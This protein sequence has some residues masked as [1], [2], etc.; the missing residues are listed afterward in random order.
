MSF[1]AAKNI[2]VADYVRPN[3]GSFVDWNGDGKKDFIG[4]EF[5]H[6]IRFYKN[7]GSG[8]DG[9]EPKFADAQG[10]KIVKPY[11]IMM[12]SGADAVD[13]NGDGDIDIITG[14]GH[15]G[16]GIRFY[17]RDYI[18]DSLNDTHPIV[19]VGKLE[20]KGAV[21]LKVVRRYADAMIEHGRDTYGQRKT[22]LFL[23]ALDRRTLKPLTIRPTPPGGIRRGDRVGLPWR[24]LVGALGA[25][26]A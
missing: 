7:V 4:C 12:I 17:E 16:S 6:S 5:E 8:K 20:A 25:G 23:S 11:S 2:G 14:Q 26:S 15:G 21:F 18:E 19:T 10:V 13:F 1:A 24:K 9:E 22:G 3:L